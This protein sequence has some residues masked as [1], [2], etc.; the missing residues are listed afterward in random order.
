MAD[1]RRLEDEVR[2][3][4]E[5][6]E[7]LEKQVGQPSYT[8]PSRAPIREQLKRVIERLTKLE[9]LERLVLGRFPKI[10]MGPARSVVER[11]EVLEAGR[12][13]PANDG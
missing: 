12:D 4:K 13:V 1:T 6:V 2:A 5:R 7:S 3:L 8:D 9:E 11:L 10:P